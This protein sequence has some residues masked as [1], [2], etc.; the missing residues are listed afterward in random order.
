MKRILALLPVLL[1][2]QVCAPALAWTRPVSGPVLRPFAFDRGN[3]Y[4]GGQHRGADIGASVSANV[5]APAGGT[6][7][8][9]EALP[10]AG[11]RSPFEPP[12]ATPPRSYTSA[13]SP[14]GEV[15]PCRKVPSSGRS[16]RPVR[17]SSARRTFTSACA[18]PPTSTGTSIRSRSFR[19]DPF[20]SAG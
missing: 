11:S 12:T 1:A 10:A 3:P 14:S 7:T 16:A 6:V 4:A 5:V 13:H 18:S 15:L 19:D 20:T 8:F 17:P 9:G 2:F